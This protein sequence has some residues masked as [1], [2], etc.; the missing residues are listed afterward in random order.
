MTSQRKNSTSPLRSQS[1]KKESL[2][3]QDSKD[4]APTPLET[5]Y[6]SMG[7]ND[8]E[9]ATEENAKLT[10][11]DSSTAIASAKSYLGSAQFVE[12]ALC[13]IFYIGSTIYISSG[14]FPQYERPI[15][16]QYLEN[17]GEYILD[18]AYNL[19]KTGSMISPTVI[20]IVT[21]VVQQVLSF[22]RKF[23]LGKSYYDMHATICSYMIALALNRI[24]CEF[25]KNHVGYFRPIFYETCQPDENYAECAYDGARGSFPSGHASISFTG[26]TLLTLYIHSRFGVG[27]H[28]GKLERRRLYALAVAAQENNKLDGSSSYPSAM[29][30]MED[31]CEDS[32]SS[33][34]EMSRARLISLVAMLPMAIATYVSA[35]RVRTNHHFPAD[36][37]GGALLGSS[38]AAFIHSLWF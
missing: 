37:I 21:L 20:V 26:L 16:Y 9:L 32:S 11:S 12:L 31:L 22:V 14:P 34:S 1:S 17:E 35:D 19:V 15:P 8:V 38:I 5:N 10:N 4:T 6:S 36:I 18:Q 25:I 27:Q 13:F 2:I 33:Y 24:M 30:N 23:V 3:E 28:K 7:K 29:N